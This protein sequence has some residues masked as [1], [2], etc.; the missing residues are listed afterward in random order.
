M[1]GL[2]KIF[3]VALIILLAI[4]NYAWAHTDVPKNEEALLKAFDATGANP[5]Q[6]NMNFNSKISDKFMEIE[7]LK[8][9]GIKLIQDFELVEPIDNDSNTDERSKD[10][11]RIYDIDVTELLDM[12]QISIWGKDEEGRMITIILASE[13]DSTD[14]F[15][16]TT[17]FIDVTQNNKVDNIK[18]IRNKVDNILSKFNSET[19]ISTCIIGTF[20]GQLKSE[21]EIAKISQAM[22]KIQGNKVE[23]LFDSSTTSV[24]IY[25][26]NIDR[27]IF[28]GNNKMNL[29]V[30]MRYNEYEDKTYIWMG[31][32]IITTG[33]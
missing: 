14:D 20:K 29:N 18:Y 19:E 31:T 17:L 1:K 22:G 3:L 10:Y 21:E 4:V 8:T 25:T 28:T 24:S 5:L 9:L 33:Y 16:Q 7:E 11:E 2:R 13:K 32:P 12:N 15:Q 26:P 27:Y 6:L 23:G 30:S